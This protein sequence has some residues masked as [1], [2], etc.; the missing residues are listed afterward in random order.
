[1]NCMLNSK[2]KKKKAER[3]KCF[4]TTGSQPSQTTQ[5]NGLKKQPNQGDGKRMNYMLNSKKREKCFVTTRSQPSQTTQSNGL[6]LTSNF[7]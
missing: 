5:P 6:E 7:V 4:V 1:M 3:E 2:K